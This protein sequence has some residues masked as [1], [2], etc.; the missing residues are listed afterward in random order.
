LQ[1]PASSTDKFKNRSEKVMKNRSLV[2]AIW[3]GAALACVVDAAA[4]LAGEATP[5]TLTVG[6]SYPSIESMAIYA[7]R[8]QGYFRDEHLAV[9]LIPL[10]T[11]DKIAF[12]LLGGSIDVA[13]YTPDWIIRAIE[14]GGS[15]LKIVL[16]SANN[17]IFSL[18]AANEIRSH[19]DLKG[20]RIGVSAIA[21]ADASLTIK[22]LA[23]RG[24]NKADYVLIQAGSSPERAAALRAGSLS[25]TLIT[26]PIDE[27]IIDEGGFKRLDWSTDVISRYA[28]GAEA[29]RE[30]WARDHKPKLLAYMRAWIKASR[31]LRDPKN[32]EDVIRVLARETKI[33]DR[34]A[35]RMYDLHYGPDAAAVPKD[36]ELDLVGYQ[37]LLSDMVDRGQIGPAVPAPEKY[38]D[39]AY[40]QEAKKALD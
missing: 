24:L 12:A 8:E 36:G 16:G 26:P 29:V 3:M 39:Q 11:G 5:M 14:K 10:A 22:M 30:D 38:V 33:E 13:R 18:I 28:W 6:T 25:A 40:W 23:A 2:A 1:E 34:H 4:A 20:K 35:R 31:W 37:A 7:A 19:S 27:K 32:K 17:L 15:K 9:D 21:A